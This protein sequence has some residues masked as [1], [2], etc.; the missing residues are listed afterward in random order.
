M[1]VPAA[2]VAQ[3]RRHMHR[4]AQAQDHATVAYQDL[5]KRF[6]DLLAS[7]GPTP[8]VEEARN[9]TLFACEA[10]LDSVI[11]HRVATDL[12]TALV[13]TTKRRSVPEAKPKRPKEPPY[14]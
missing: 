13:P 4:C 11:A 10:L 12:Y 3:A 8:A 9:N 5:M 14:A 7:K 2:A 6:T 1:N